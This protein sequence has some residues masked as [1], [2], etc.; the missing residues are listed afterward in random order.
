MQKRFS[1]MRILIIS[2]YFPPL[3]AIGSLRPYSWA[4]TW[5]DDG[6]DVTVLTCEPPSHASQGLD[7]EEFNFD[8]IRVPLPRF[9]RKLQDRFHR[10]APS[11]SPPS[12]ET[13]SR[14]VLRKLIEKTRK[15][16]GIFSTSRMPDFHAWWVAPAYHR[17][18][19]GQWD[20]VVS[21]YTP[22]ASHLIARRLQRIN[23]VAYWVADFRDLW[24]DNQVHSGLFPFNQRERWLERRIVQGADMVTTVS[25]PL[26]DR[27]QKLLPK[28][29]VVT[30]ENGVFAQ[31][32]DLLDPEPYFNS[33]DKFR[34]AYTGTTYPEKRDPGPLFQAISALKRS[35][36]TAVLANQIEVIFAGRP[37]SYIECLI[38]QYELCSQVRCIGVVSRSDALRIQ[39]DADLLLFTAWSANYAGI[40]TGKLFEYGASGTP[41]LSVGGHPNDSSDRLILEY[42][43]GWVCRNDIDAIQRYLKTILAGDLP[44]SHDDA[45]RD[46]FVHRFDRNRLAR[47]LLES[48]R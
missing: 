44:C 37:S 36:Q 26:A 46:R 4:K 43:L 11:N 29:P 40:L 12:K 22:Y 25:D 8:V 5:Q 13:G 27:L 18:C 19:A 28:R 38:D 17:V 2:S 35:P 32:L 48:V 1:P 33:T 10:S 7:V 24:T 42:G 3:N 6:H 45:Q 31:E 23:R 21:T 14:G 20:L 39:R 47:K 41:I 30:I 34:I 15:R 16:T 9:I